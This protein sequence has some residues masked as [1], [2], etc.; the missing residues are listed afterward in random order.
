MVVEAALDEFDFDLAG[1]AGF[2]A[3]EEEGAG[4][5]EGRAGVVGGCESLDGDPAFVVELAGF[6]VEVD[7]ARL[8]WRPSKLTA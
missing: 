4:E 5:A 6:E 8:K 2:E 7:V 1:F 3:A